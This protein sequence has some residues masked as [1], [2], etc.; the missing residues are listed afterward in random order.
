MPIGAA[1]EHDAYRIARQVHDDELSVT[2]GIKSLTRAGVNPNSAGGFIY[3]FRSMLSGSVYKRAMSTGATEYFLQ[4][5]RQDYG[6]EAQ[7]KAVS[8]LR[9]HIAYKGGAMPGYK[10]IADRCCPSTRQDVAPRIEAQILPMSEKESDWQSAPEVQEEYFL[11]RLPH[12]QNGS[13]RCH[14]LISAPT[15]STVLFQYD[16]S[17]IAAAQLVGQGKLPK[18]DE[19]GYTHELRF[20]TGTIRVFDPIDLATVQK[21]WPRVKGLNRARWKLDARRL[22]TFERHLLN[23]RRPRLLDHDAS[24]DVGP[25]DSS[26]APSGV[27]SRTVATAQIRLRRGQYKF[28]QTLLARYGSKC[29]VTGSS[30]VALLEAAHIS[31]FRGEDD[32]HVENGLLLRADIHTLFDLNLL[33]IEPETLK[34]ELHQSI[35]S[36]YREWADIRLKCSSNATPSKAALVKRWE[37]FRILAET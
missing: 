14:T 27:D 25:G 20:D 8:A 11:D 31:P 24:M 4:Q 18:K 34:V 3:I 37:E 29:V 23:V 35:R 16:G 12:A 9:Q 15:G 5:I 33:G 26:Y 6:A 22:S 17:I 30:I 28:R 32:N 1:L 21:I 2:D 7:R 36:E 19:N 10:A 13:Y